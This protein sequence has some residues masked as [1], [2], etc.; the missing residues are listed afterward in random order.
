MSEYEDCPNCF[1]SKVNADA[2][3]ASVVK[4]E[5]ELAEAQD[6]IAELRQA[7][8]EEMSDEINVKLAEARGLLREARSYWITLNGPANEHNLAVRIDAFLAEKE[9]ER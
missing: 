1:A 9:G 3:S 2:W 8:A 5:R 6:K 4:L 7:L